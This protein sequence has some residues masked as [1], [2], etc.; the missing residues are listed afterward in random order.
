MKPD[1]DHCRGTRFVV[2]AQAIPQTTCPRCGSG[3]V[4]QPMQTMDM[5]M[6]WECLRCGHM[7]MSGGF[8]RSGPAHRW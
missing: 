3:E 2:H 6:R 7:N 4:H 8:D 5:P 1:I